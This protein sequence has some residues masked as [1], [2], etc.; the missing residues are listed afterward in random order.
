MKRKGSE[1]ER[2]M[3]VGIWLMLEDGREG[4]GFYIEFFGQLRDGLLGIAMV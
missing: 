4:R 3:E 2:E 1:K